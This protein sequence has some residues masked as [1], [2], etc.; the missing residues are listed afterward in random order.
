M[1]QSFFANYYPLA[2]SHEI[3]MI[4]NFFIFM[5]CRARAWASRR[6]CEILVNRICVNGCPTWSPLQKM[7]A[8]S[9]RIVV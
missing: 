1:K 9:A 7:I 3:K 6:T 2:T 4:A 8:N 5:F